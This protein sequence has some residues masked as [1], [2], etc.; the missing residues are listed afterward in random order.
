MIKILKKNH[1]TILTFIIPLILILIGFTVYRDYGISLDEEITRENGIVTIKYLYEFLFPQSAEN[2]KLIQNVPNLNEYWQKQYGTFFEV[3]VIATIEILLKVKDF[4]EI[5]YY[6]HLMNHYL[7]II[8]IICFYFLCLNIFKNKLYAFFGAGILYTTPRI[9]AESFYNSKDLA[10]LSFFIFLIFFAIKFIKKPNYYNAFLLSIFASLA[11]NLRIVAFYVVILVILFF[12]I[13]F[14]MKNKFNQKKINILFFLLLSKLFFLYLTWPFLWENPIN[15]FIFALT[16]TQDPTRSWGGFVFYFGNFYK[17][18]YLP[19]H[20]LI[21]YFFATTPLIISILIACGLIQLSLRFFKRLISIDYKNSY[22][23][24]WRS[25]KEKIFVFLFFSILIPIFLIF[26]TN[27]IIY[28]G[29][30]H[31]FFLYPPLILISIYFID[32]VVIKFRNKKISAYINTI[33]VIIL[34]SNIYN[35]MI[36]HPFQYIYFNSIFEKN[37]NRLLEIDY[38]GLS[39]KYSLE[40]LV[41]NNIERSKITIGVAS[42]TNLNL[43]KKMLNKKYKNKLIISGQDFTKADFIF[44]NNHYE[45]NPNYDNKYRIPKNY[46]KHSE[47][48]KGKILINEFYIKE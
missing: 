3:L 21:V 39:N 6:R 31:L 46:R 37:A 36:L 30:R 40:K 4:S 28:N 35:Q 43:S 9:F 44:S 24:I 47:L 18:Y 41:K 14:L 48:K 38:W 34:L 10:F 42:F 45:I 2:L 8:S 23:D 25:E 26:L 7:F 16:S 11:T 19:W 12:V 17:V 5:F 15:N 13:E 32:I 29:W 22:N 1:N 33:L 20:Y 27:T